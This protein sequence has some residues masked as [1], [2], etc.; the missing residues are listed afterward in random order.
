MTRRKFITSLVSIG[1]VGKYAAAQNM[2]TTD[3]PVTVAFV[4][5]GPIGDQG[6]T[7]SHEEGRKFAASYFKDKV[8]FIVV[9]RV[10]EGDDS[11]PV[12]EELIKQGCN[13][14]FGTTFG[15][16]EPMARLA[17]KYP[18]VK[19]ENATGYKLDKNL[20]PYDIK[21]YEGAYLGGI[22]AGQTTKTGSLGVVASIPIPEVIRN[23]NAFALGAQ[24]VLKNVQINVEWA[25][26]WFNPEIEYALATKLISKGVDVL[27][28]TTDSTSIIKAAEEYGKFA[29]GIYSDL[30]AFGANAHLGSVVP[31]WGHYYIQAINQY[32]NQT[33]SPDETWWGLSEDSIDIVGLNPRL[34][35]F[36][37]NLIKTA[38][39]KI[40]KNQAIIWSGPIYDQSGRLVTPK[41]AQMTEDQVKYMAFFVK[42]INGTIARRH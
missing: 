16:M 4:Y 26:S 24:S 18:H 27:F 6:W 36:L 19:F 5:V 10:P 41:F 2:E 34:S 32:M 31:I 37:L 1:A 29:I 30:T 23:I 35:E 8:K 3:K 39:E 40:I 22:L 11:I 12:F 20:R 42:G 14:I 21:I 15:Y 28:Q 13:I 38:K 25:N 17:K 33:W 9:E 7:Y